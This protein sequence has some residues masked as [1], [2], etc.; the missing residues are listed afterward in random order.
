LVT[1]AR[2]DDQLS[3][4]ESI[5][6]GS[7]GLMLLLAFLAAT[8]GLVFAL[9]GAPRIGRPAVRAAD[10]QPL[11]GQSGYAVTSLVLSLCGL[12][13]GFTAPLGIAFAVAAF[14]DE[15]QSGGQRTGR[16]LAIAGLVI[17]IVIVALS[18]LFMAIF[19]GTA[20]PS[21]SESR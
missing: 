14:D 12:L 2:A 21:F 13:V 10:G 11:R 1:V 19:I 4:G 16:G 5:T 20:D 8:I 18:A 6:L 15:K 9:V 17:G 3:V 7:G